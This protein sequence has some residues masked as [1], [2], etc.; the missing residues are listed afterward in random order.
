MTYRFYQPTKIHFGCG[1]VNNVGDIV[2]RYGNKCLLVTTEDAP[3]LNDLY[4]RVKEILRDSGIDVWHFDKVKPNPTVDIVE[5][6]IRALDACN[7]DLVLTVG[8]GSS[9]DTAKSIALLRGQNLDWD[10]YFDNLD[11][12]FGDYEK[13]G[14]MPLVSIPTTAGT[15]S[16]VTQAAVI[17]KGDDKRTIFHPDNFSKEAILDPELL[18]TLP[19]SLTAS[20]GFDAFSHAFESY[21]SSNSTPLSEMYAFEAMKIILDVLPRAVEMPGEIKYRQ[22][23]MRAQ[24]LAGTALA[25]GGAHAPHPLSEI[26]GGITHISH[27]EALALIYPEF[28]HVFKDEHAQKFDRLGDLFEGDLESGVKSFLESIG[29][30]RKFDDYQVSKDQ[31]DQI[32]TCPVLGFLPFGSKEKLQSVI[33]KSYNR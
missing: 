12:P 30:Y 32:M 33:E 22:A 1:Q 24:M 20:T 14:D 4:K 6:G 17:S 13:L 16:E 28:I 21:V 19:R 2:K 18:L 8:G 7:A 5:A 31:K 29:L 3:P 25:N 11:N 9:I 27:G 10:Y 15:G 23:L 26:I